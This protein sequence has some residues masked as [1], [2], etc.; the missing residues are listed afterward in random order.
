[1]KPQSPRR[2]LL[3]AA[4]GGLALV[5]GGIASLDIPLLS[6]LAGVGLAGL[7]LLSLLW[8]AWRA[9]RAFLWKV[10]RRLAFSYFLIGGLPIP[11]ALLLLGLLVYLVAGLFLGHLYR[12]AAGELQADLQRAAGR[13]AEELGAPGAPQPEREGD[14]AFGYYRDGRRVAGDGRTPAVWPAWAQGSPE[15]SDEVRL[16]DARP[17]GERVQPVPTLAAAAPLAGQE[18]SGVVAFYGGQLDQELGRRSGFWVELNQVGDES[19]R[20]VELVL[21]NLRFP[22]LNI[23]KDHAEAEKFFKKS[24]QN[25]WL[26]DS[27]MLWWGEIYGRPASLAAGQPAPG[28]LAVS[29]NSTPRI[30]VAHFAANASEFDARVWAALVVLA[31]LLFEVY[32]VATLMAVAIIFSL[33]R[34][35]NRLSSATSRIQEGDFS[36]RIPVRRKDQVGELQRSFNDM[37]ANLE[38][39]VDSAAQKELLDK[40]LALARDLQKSLIPAQLPAGG[41]DLATLFEPSAA[42]GGDY[43]DVLRL[44]DGQLAVLIADVSGHGLPAGLRMAMIKAAL[45]V[46][47]DHTRDPREILRRLDGVVRGHGQRRRSFVTATLG[48][49]DPRTGRLQL[50]NAGHPPTYWIRAGR[51]TQEI[52]LPGSALGGLGQHYGQTEIR[53]EQG[54]VVVWLS[55]GLIEAVNPDGEP[56]DYGGIQQTLTDIGWGATA[57]EVRDGLLADVERHAAGEPFGDDRT[58]VVLRWTGEGVVGAEAGEE[59]RVTA[60]AG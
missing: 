10:G 46:L 15:E 9:L 26:W 49:L 5:L 31:I 19:L 55:D 41:V 37:A 25:V 53:L 4:L 42:I 1:M 38:R 54:D 56:F 12:D 14:I 36:A 58:L 7:V 30:L 34:A 52:L 43:F 57:T 47:V 48:L 50:T 24:S 20:T 17:P 35:V 33:S 6:A 40:E 51:E 8:L 11:M 23:R 2:L 13:R 21:W 59:E 39:L 44:P 22:L 45:T 29:V 16:F 60:V 27:P 28:E 18:G 32:L 3:L